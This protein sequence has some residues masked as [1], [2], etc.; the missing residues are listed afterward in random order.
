[1]GVF[2]TTPQFVGNAR[3]AHAAGYAPLAV[4][5][6]VPVK[7]SAENGEIRP[8]DLLVASSTLGHAMRC[9]GADECFGKTIGKALTSLDAGRGT[10]TMVVG[11][12]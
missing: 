8:G 4:S 12:A 6:I 7:A 1:M 2:A 10:V 3:F 11:L 9:E 5:G